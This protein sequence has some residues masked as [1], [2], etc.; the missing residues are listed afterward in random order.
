MGAKQFHLRIRPDDTYLIDLPL[1][2]VGALAP[3][4][5]HLSLGARLAI[6]GVFTATRYLDVMREVGANGCLLVGTMAPALLATPERPDDAD[7]AWRHAYISPMVADPKGF[8]QRFGLDEVWIAF[9]GTEMGCVFYTEGD[10]P[11]PRTVGKVRPGMEVRIVDEHDM[12]LPPGEVGELVMRTSRPWEL[13]LGYW[14][15]PEKTV[16]VWR[17]GWYHSGD[18]FTYD[19]DGNYY[20]VDRIKDSLRRRGE[21]IS[22]F[23][24]EREVVTHPDVL[25]AACVAA[26]GRFENDDEVK[27]FVVPVERATIDPAEL[28]QYL[29]P[30]M[31]YFMVP[32]YVEVVDELPKTPTAKVKKHELRARGNTEATW[33]REQAGIVVNRHS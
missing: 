9:G 21:N 33:D 16:E 30:R 17:N 8:A 5:A 29:V 20:F 25:E 13:N 23:E 3:L 26:P 10:I 32:R 14:N 6:R 15:N 12:P 24:V 7:N 4:I 28:I 31:P 11:D 27:I 1:F 19:E 22:S 2:H 18:G